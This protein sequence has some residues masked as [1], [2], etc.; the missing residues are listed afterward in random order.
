MKW[1]F[2][3][4]FLILMPLLAFAEVILPGSVDGSVDYAVLIGQLIANPK[5]FSA[6]IIGALVI[7]GIVQ[8]L[9]SPKLKSIFKSVPEPVQFLIITGLGQVYAILVH[10]YV[11]HDQNISVALVGIFS[12][13]AAASIYNAAI[14]VFGKK[15]PA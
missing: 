9:K 15:K 4:T 7:L 12:S 1:I 3:I 14:L 8:A 11:I 2:F 10:V 13:G 6:V 5:A